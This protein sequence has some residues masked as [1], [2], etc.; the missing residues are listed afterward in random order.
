MSADEMGPCYEVSDDKG[1][2][3]LAAIHRFLSNSYWAAGIPMAVLER[4]IENSLCIGVY[5]D[6]EQV[7]FARV[8]SDKATFAYL[9]DV[10]VVESHRGKGLAAKLMDFVESHPDLQ[11]IRRKMLVTRDAHGL[12]RKYGY[13]ASNKPE[14]ILE[15]RLENPYGVP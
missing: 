2:L 11:C 6:A 1:R 14:N 9:A 10:Y 8:I 5:H 12:Y 7:G 3:D 13:H 15:I 4:A